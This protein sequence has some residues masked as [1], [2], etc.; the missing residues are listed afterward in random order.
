MNEKRIRGKMQ[1][2]VDI[3][4]SDISTIRSGKVTPALVEDLE[5]LVYGGQQKLKV[6]ELATISATDSQTIVIDPWDKSIIGE[7]RKGIDIAGPAER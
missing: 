2:V 3:V 6:N 4:A 1:A 5:V 7:I